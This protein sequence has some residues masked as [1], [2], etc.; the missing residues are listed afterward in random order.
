MLE[1]T[2]QLASDSRFQLVVAHLPVPHQPYIYDRHSRQLVPNG[3]TTYLDN[4]VLT[5]RAFAAIRS[6]M[7]A[8]NTWDATAVVITS[9]HWW[10]QNGE[11]EPN[12]GLQLVDPD[13]ETPDHRI[14]L[15]VRMPGQAEGLDVTPALAALEVHGLILGILA[16]EIRE[17]RSVQRYL[18]K[19]TVKPVPE[20]A[21]F[22]LPVDRASGSIAE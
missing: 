20:L 22:N 1:E 19:A 2:I 12:D 6:G 14:P 13:P 9:D 10:R 11:G 18:S 7:E 17:P 8:A 4:L 15:I 3:G 16:G 21:G 5:D